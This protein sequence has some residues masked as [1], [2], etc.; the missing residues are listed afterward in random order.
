TSSGSIWP[1]GPIYLGEEP[2]P[3]TGSVTITTPKISRGGAPFLTDARFDFD[4][5]ATN[6]GVHGLTAAFGPGKLTLDANLCCA[7]PLADKQLGGQATLNGVPLDQLLPP[8]PA[9]TLS[10]T[11]QGS[12][13]FSGTG[14]S[15]SALLG[16]LSGDGSFE[17]DDLAVQKFDPGAFATVASLGGII[18]IKEADLSAKVAS[19]IDAGPFSVPKLNGG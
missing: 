17:V 7:G 15:I 3:T 10:G 8:A 12:A 1:D 4:W 11:L 16:N 18:N 5:D 2:R 19:A 6:S 14:D 13:R 9:A